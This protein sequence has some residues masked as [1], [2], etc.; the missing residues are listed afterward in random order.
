MKKIIINALVCL[1]LCLAGKVHGQEKSYAPSVIPPSPEAASLSRFVDYQ[2]S[3]YTGQ[4]S[5]SI[6][7][8]TFKEGS[9]EMPV[10]LLYKSGGFQV[11]EASSRVGLGWTLGAGGVISRSMRGK[12]DEFN[13]NNGAKGFLTLRGET[14]YEFLTSSVN[15]QVKY[16]HLKEISNGCT[17][18]QPDVF[19]F[20]VNGYSGKF[21][22]DWDGNLVVDSD[23]PMEVSPIWSGG[24]NTTLL[25]W[26]VT[27]S[28]GVKYTFNER[29]TTSTIFANAS[30]V[31]NTISYTSSWFLSKIETPSSSTE[32]R[33]IDFSYDNYTINNHQVNNSA[34]RV[35][36]Y[37]GSCGGN[38][39]GITEY[40][41]N[42]LTIEGK[43]L[44][45][46]SGEHNPIEIHFKNGASRTDLSG[47]GLY[48]LGKIEIKDAVAN[49][50]VKSFD[51]EHDYSTNR[52]TLLSVK[53]TS[54][55]LEKSPYLFDYIG[56]LKDR[57]TNSRDYW[58]FENGNGNALFP[59]YAIENQ[60]GDG[61]VY[62]GSADRDPSLAGSQSG[63]LNK[64]TYPTGGYD[65]YTYELHDYANINGQPLNEYKVVNAGPSLSSNGNV[66]QGSSGNADLKT[67]SFTVNANPNDASEKIVLRIN[68]TEI[69]AFSSFTGGS[70]P[71]AKIYK[72]GESTPVLSLGTGDSGDILN[73]DFD[74][75]DYYL[76]TFAKWK[77]CVSGNT[78]RDRVSVSITYKKYTNELL[79][80]KEAGGVRVSKIEK[81]DSDG[82]LLLENNYKYLLENGNSSGFIYGEPK[83]FV[84]YS[85]KFSCLEG[86]LGNQC[87]QVDCGQQAI[88]STSNIIDLGATQGNHIGY[89]RVTVESSD[90][91]LGNQ[92]SNYHI[93]PNII[94][95]SPPFAP[96]SDS[97]FRS[98]L[99]ILSESKNA[100]DVV[101]SSSTY[102]YEIYSQ[103]IPGLKVAFLG[104][105]NFPD[106]KY[107]LGSYSTILGHVKMSSQSSSQFD[108]NGTNSLETYSETT[109]DTQV[110]NVVE[111]RAFVNGQ[112]VIS[113][114][115]YSQDV[116]SPTHPGVLVMNTF[117]LRSVPIEVVSLVKESGNEYVTGAVYYDYDT[118]LNLSAVYTFDSQVRVPV[119]NFTL[120]INNAGN[121][122]SSYHNVPEVVL[123]WDSERNLID[124]EAD[125][126]VRTYLYDSR[127]FPIASITGAEEDQVFYEGFEEN[128]SAATGSAKTG[129]RYQNVGSFN[130]LT[131]GSFTPPVGVE[132]VMSYW[133]LEG[134]IWKYSGEIP[135][136]NAITAG[137]ALDEIRVYKK[138]AQMTTYTYDYGYG[139][140]TVTDPNGIPTYFVYDELGRLIQQKDQD[141]NTL[142]QNE[143]NYGN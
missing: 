127:F 81:F 53:E 128:F 121:R 91:S 7:I 2:V 41:N 21:Q 40:A 55:T 90:G 44:K 35:H 111:K 102:D 51:L 46:I 57:D 31:V 118:D 72:V 95:F 60:V 108:V 50:V 9:L 89:K 124:Q 123:N 26:E 1:F 125:G 106:S 133:Y 132:M 115:Y 6:P 65:E 47:I 130:F 37:N 96:P 49:Q 100:S 120:A 113:R 80:Y 85:Q 12:P 27:V 101:V 48:E 74:P 129:D 15:S 25:G 87:S 78:D 109:Y 134:S 22:F 52:L 24:F 63:V 135:F 116:V 122:N 45:K 76:E 38:F 69:H 34:T 11:E 94:K 39:A 28:N 18:A 10:S 30:C 103:S 143:Y 79:T 97:S 29:E 99:L 36:S 112:Q 66:C 131:Q 82:T 142:Q 43:I 119:S 54:G 138:G 139:V 104:G 56:Q 73:I 77:S 86:D 33:F 20:N 67:S 141:G 62:Y 126:V 64:I 84:Y 70:P 13:T 88:V 93:S 17:D 58:G 42:I 110:Q 105:N 8:T 107:Q 114:T 14:T 140:T 92:V 59:V 83:Q 19:Y 5:I 3:E 98:G 117:H 61:F 68:V 23:S 71:Y 32:N 136:A 16:N 4:T 75:G 137:S